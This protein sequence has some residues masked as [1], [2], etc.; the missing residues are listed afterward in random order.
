MKTTTIKLLLAMMALSF[1]VIS[2]SAQNLVG[3]RIDVQG[4]HYADKMWL[5]SVATTTR[6][7]DSGW[8]G[9]KMFGSPLAPQLFAME[10]AGN[11]QIDVIPNLNN[12]YL[13][14]IAGQDS[15][16]TFT[17]THQNL[18]LNYTHLYLI[19]SVANTTVDIYP[20]GTKYI[21][22]ANNKTI[23]KRFKI[24]TT[25]AQTVAVPTPLTVAIDSTAA[26]VTNQTT[27]PVVPPTALTS[28]SNPQNKS[29]TINVG[30]GNNDFISAQKNLN[31]YATQNTIVVE[32]PGSQRGLL[33][34][35]NAMSGKLIKTMEFNANGT[36]TMQADVPVGSY[37]V[38]G[39][40]Q[41]EE[42]AK[43]VI[44]R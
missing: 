15:V 3:T 39:V 29:T 20:N 13:G 7:F 10:D 36:T 40:S 37:V 17:F 34:L 42:I 30:G 26:A 28:T 21:F 31:I 5:F 18:A 38:H 27:V 12:S 35:Y 23:E 6:G 22:M 19:D 4:A 11:F 32:N 44:L 25:L 2:A 33:S 16:Y 9:Y 43:T 14:F 8:D 41:N 1:L 24:V